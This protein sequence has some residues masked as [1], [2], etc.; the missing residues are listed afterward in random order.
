[1]V[2]SPN[3]GS[4]RDPAGFIFEHDQ[5]IYRAVADFY[6]ADYDLLMKSGLYADLTSPG[7]LIQHQE[8]LPPPVNMP[9]GYN[10]VLKPEMVPFISYPY[11]W[12][13]S[14]LKS[15][16][17]L[18]LDIQARAMEYGL[19][20]KD[21]SAFNVTWNKGRPVFLDTLSFTALKDNQP[22]VAYG[23]FC[24]HFLAPLT[25]MSAR[26]LRLQALTREN[27]PGISLDLASKLLPRRSWFNLGSLLHIHLHA[28]SRQKHAST[29]QKAT[30]TLTK[31]SLMNLVAGLRMAVEALKFPHTATE[32][33]DYYNDTNYT[34]QQFQ[35]KKDVIS[36]WIKQFN[37]KTVCDLGANDGTFSRLAEESASLI[38]AADIDPIAVEL[39][40][41]RCQQDNNEVMLPLL[42]DLTQPSPSLGWQLKERAGLFSR[43]K[44]DLGLALALVHHLA[45]TNNTPLPKIGEML[46]QAAPVWIVEFPD[47]ADSQV[48][49]LLLNR[50][51]IFPNYTT[52]G[53]EQALEAMFLIVKIHHITNS[54]R[55]LYLVHRKNEASAI[56]R[57]PDD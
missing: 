22:W 39:N 2:L 28:R 46:A 52:T 23:Q 41:R 20:L 6:R 9:Q 14:Q 30:A 51:D 35:E 17:L 42:Q 26:D 19:T 31:K 12:S 7:W 8:I 29:D 11:E 4:F 32:W 38:I 21:A 55:T 10:L 36:D 44:A 3:P 27:L 45:I 54:Y 18:T 5:V 50:E 33:G 16:A 25:L 43:L 40:Y 48:Q 37:P 1:M 56:T 24:S 53:F 34:P 15:A 57:S 13:F 47:K 49:R